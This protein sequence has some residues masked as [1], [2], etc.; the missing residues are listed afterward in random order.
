MS[1]WFRQPL[2]TA[3]NF[4]PA[5][6]PVTLEVSGAFRRRPEGKSLLCGGVSSLKGELK[7]QPIPPMGGLIQIH[8]VHLT[9]AR[10]S[11]RLPSQ[12]R[13]PSHKHFPWAFCQMDQLSCAVFGSSETTRSETGE[14]AC[15]ASLSFPSLS[16]NSLRRHKSARRVPRR[17]EQQK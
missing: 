8:Q 17:A 7:H 2:Q 11:A 1:T 5:S 3:L 12:L 9:N 14:P 15:H 6:Q 4:Q 10:R 16:K 13:L